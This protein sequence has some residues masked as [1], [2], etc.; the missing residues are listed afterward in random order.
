[1][2]TRSK[3]RKRQRVKSLECKFR[4]WTGLITDRP[5]NGKN[6][7]SRSYKLAIAAKLWLL[8]PRCVVELWAKSKNFWIAGRAN[9]LNLRSIGSLSRAC[10]PSLMRTR[11]S[12]F[13]NSSP[14][15]SSPRNLISSRLIFVTR[16]K[17]YEF[18]L[19]RQ[20]LRY[21]CRVEQTWIW[22]STSFSV[23]RLTIELVYRCVFYIFFPR[24][25]S[26]LR[27]FRIAPRVGKNSR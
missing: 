10:N 16:S 26:I 18:S 14:L 3:E 9:K 8:Y 20:S 5:P 2:K 17:R 1:M 23:R 7:P 13:L 6:D 15:V 12:R 24:W 27:E 4:N 19:R 22:P 11:F 21:S 25:D